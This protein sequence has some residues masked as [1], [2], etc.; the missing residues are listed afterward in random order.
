ME[1]GGGIRVW[2]RENAT[3][4]GFYLYAVFAAPP[5]AKALQAGLADAQTVA[6]PGLLL[7]GVLLL[8]PVGLRWKVL[9][10]RRRN[11]DEGFEP[12][13][14]M[15]G[16]GSATVIGHM[17]VA[18]LVGMAALDCLGLAGEGAND[19]WAGGGVLFL[20]GKD[21][22][23]LFATGGPSVSRELPGHWKERLADFLLLA[24][25]CVAYSVWWQVLFDLGDVASQTVGMK[26][27]L[28]I[29]LGGV[30]A[31]F[32][33]PMRLPFVLEECYRQPSRG[34]KKR[35][36]TELVLGA[37]LGFYPSFFA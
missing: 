31:L 8:E 1:T 12:Q 15:L 14:S 29:L 13:G 10:L 4:L 37:L 30:F 21:L 2:V 23:A 6:W 35:L 27:A 20:V 24:F 32:Y 9:F 33:L 26:V 36:W 7:L 22:L 16:L 34:R 19:N 28:A 17:I 5:L 25:S 18:T 3:S 11:R